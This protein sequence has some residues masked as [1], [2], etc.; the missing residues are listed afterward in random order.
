MAKVQQAL[1][2][3]QKAHELMTE[4]QNELAPTD[5]ALR[6]NPKRNLAIA[7]TYTED[8]ILRLMVTDEVAG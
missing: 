2:L 1:E 6:T 4:R 8:A 3:L 5:E 7:L